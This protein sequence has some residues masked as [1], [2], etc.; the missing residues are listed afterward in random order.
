MPHTYSKDRHRHHLSEAPANPNLAAS[1]TE[2]REE[3][4]TLLISRKVWGPDLDVDNVTP[5]WQRA[6][7]I[8]DGRVPGFPQAPIQIGQGSTIENDMESYIGH[9]MEVRIKAQPGETVGSVIQKALQKCYPQTKSVPAPHTLRYTLGDFPSHVIQ[10]QEQGLVDSPNKPI[11]GVEIFLS[12]EDRLDWITIK[13]STIIAFL[14]KP[15]KDGKTGEIHRTTQDGVP[16]TTL[17]YTLDQGD[18]HQIFV[19]IP[20]TYTKKG[21][22]PAYT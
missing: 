20:D 22:R 4:P 18:G 14:P 8:Q 17:F 10:T 15:G 12:H 13:D 16:E 19:R 7:L 11:F 21:R 9:V 1:G 2:Q 5:N 3:P 6:I